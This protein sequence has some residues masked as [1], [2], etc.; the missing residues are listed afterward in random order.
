MVS[1]SSTLAMMKLA[2]PAR[3]TQHGM[4]V[5]LPT[6]CTQLHEKCLVSGWGSTVPGQ[7]EWTIKPGEG[8]MPHNCLSDQGSTVVCGGELQ[9]LLW[10]SSSDVGLY[11]RLCLY[12]DWISD[13]M[14]TPDPTHEPAWT[15]PAAATT[16]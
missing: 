7:G 12:L 16:W 13:I 15:T 3:F 9:G 10:S 6:R 11:T 8:Y 14:N 1:P 5:A 2:E 4:P